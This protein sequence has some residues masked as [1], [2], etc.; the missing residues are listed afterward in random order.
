MAELKNVLRIVCEEDC[1]GCGACISICPKEALYYSQDTY[2]FIHPSLHENQCINCGKC[3]KTCP[4]LVAIKQTPIKALA[5]ISKSSNVVKSSSSGG[6]FYEVASY[7]IKNNGVV[8]GCI[9]DDSF[10][11]KHTRVER[12]EEL[13]PLMR[14]KYVQSDLNFIFRDIEKDL[15]NGLC[16]LFAGTP[17]QVSSLKNY[18]STIKHSGRLYTIDIVCHGVPSQSFFNSYIDSLKSK[19]G[20]ID[21]FVFRAKRT[22]RNGMNW[23]YSFRRKGERKENFRNWPS[24]SYAYYYMM[25]YLNRESCYHCKYSTK[26]RVGDFTLCD[27][28]HWEK[29]SFTFKYGSTVSGVFVNS[30]EAQEL[31][32]HINQNFLYQETNVEHI[33]ENNGCL[34]RPVKKPVDRNIILE[35]YSNGGFTEVDTYFCANHKS[36]IKKEKLRML[37]P[38]RLL[39]LMA[40]IIAKA[41]KKI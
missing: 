23:F 16:V 5:A 24:D 2:G 32:Q 6:V 10:Q 41:K 4:A 34:K 37:V 27:F 33:V 40:C 31:F 11:V 19:E 1:C 15:K 12:I 14:S 8:Y 3:L 36:Q 7:I 26:E 21:S 20:E 17:C 30:K 29:Y 13:V 28:W 35:K 9:M 39:N 38:Q 22:V 25:S 18:V